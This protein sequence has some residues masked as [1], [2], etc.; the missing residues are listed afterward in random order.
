MPR[1]INKDPRQY[2]RLFTLLSFFKLC[3]SGWYGVLILVILLSCK[4]PFTP[5]IE[6]EETGFLVVEGYIN[7]GPDAITTIRLSRTSK[8]AESIRLIDENGATVHI[9]DENGNIYPLVNQGMGKY[10]S[11]ELSLS[12]ENRFRLS[13]LMQNEK[14]YYSE[15]EESFVTPPIDSVVWR[16]IYEGVGI[17]VNTHDPDNNIHYYQWDYEEVWEIR[18]VA[19][20]WYDYAGG[21]IVPRP[22]EEIEAMFKCWKYDYPKRLLIASTAG[23]T[24]DVIPMRRL[25]VIPVSDEKLSDRYSVVVRQHAISKKAFEYL[26][27]IDKNTTDVGSWF[28]PQPSELRGNIYCTSSDEPVVGFVGAATATEQRIFILERQV[29]E[30]NFVLYC[31]GAGAHKDEPDSLAKY[32]GT[33]QF[34]PID[35]NTF[36]YVS[37]STIYCMDCRATRKGTRIRPDFW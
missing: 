23:L 35:I 11:P 18:S 9:E 27:M 2:F 5:K 17:F 26:Q 7:L 29:P 34:V 30:W 21:E 25:I 16:R 12:T 13:I 14:Q 24:V 19:L 10:I 20:S 3:R 32:F 28:D 1:M 15:F 37:G 36:G 4:E 8:V 31:R 33:Q 6:G 22:V